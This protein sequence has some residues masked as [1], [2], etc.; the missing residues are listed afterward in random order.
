MDALNHYH[1]YGI[2][3]KKFEAGEPVERVLYAASGFQGRGKN[4]FGT[5]IV[6]QHRGIMG[7]DQSALGSSETIDRSALEKLVSEIVRDHIENIKIT[8]DLGKSSSDIVLAFT[9]KPAYD[10]VVAFDG[11]Q[12]MFE[13]NAQEQDAVMAYARTKLLSIKEP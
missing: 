5:A 2:K 13:L 12:R 6:A 3:D 10:A 9:F 8:T 11:E 7:I 1:V 4:N